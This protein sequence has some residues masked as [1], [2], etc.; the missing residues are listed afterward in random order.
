MDSIKSK[1]EL[2][3]SFRDAVVNGDL[4]KYR[5]SP[6]HLKKVTKAKKFLSNFK[7]S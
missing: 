2:P 3:K 4:K 1:K 7:F 6:V 5:D